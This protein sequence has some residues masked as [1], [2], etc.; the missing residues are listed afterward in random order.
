VVDAF[1]AIASR[2]SIGYGLDEAVQMGP[3]R[4][5]GKKEMVLRYIEKGIERGGEAET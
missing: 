2:I 3:L 5:R 1:I 4:D